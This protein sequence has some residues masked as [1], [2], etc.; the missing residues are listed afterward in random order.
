MGSD[1]AT[2]GIN[3]NYSLSFL[4]ANVGAEVER[5]LNWLQ[6]RDEEQVGRSLARALDLLD[7]ALALNI[8]PG[9][10]RELF[11]LHEVICGQVYNPTLYNVAPETLSKYFLPFA[12]F[13]RKHS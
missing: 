9:A 1:I 13:S 3:N 11:R 5:M 6:K 12:L 2:L 10:R 4:L 8:S 7:R